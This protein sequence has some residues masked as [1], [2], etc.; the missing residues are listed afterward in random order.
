LILYDDRRERLMSA[1]AARGWR[2]AM[3]GVPLPDG[4]SVV[5]LNPR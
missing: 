5:V 2:A 3:L 1:A 4:G